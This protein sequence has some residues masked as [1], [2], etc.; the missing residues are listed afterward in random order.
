MLQEAVAAYAVA[1]RIFDS[2]MKRIEG[3]A[4]RKKPAKS[5]GP[6]KAL[7]RINKAENDLM[8]ARY[9]HLG[10]VLL[11]AEADIEVLEAQATAKDAKIARLRRQLRVARRTRRKRRG[12]STTRVRFSL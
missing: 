5:I 2:K 12:W 9:T 3:D 11:S 10:A 4:N 8:E 7:S 1:G 6:Y